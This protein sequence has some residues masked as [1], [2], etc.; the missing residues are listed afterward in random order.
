MGGTPFESYRVHHRL[1]RLR[2]ADVPQAGAGV[3]ERWLSNRENFGNNDYRKRG[4][5]YGGLTFVER[6]DVVGGQ[7]MVA[8]KKGHVYPVGPGHLQAVPRARRLDG[9][10]QYHRLEYYARMDE[11][12]KGPVLIWKSVQPAHALHL[13]EAL[14]ELT[15]KAA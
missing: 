11:K 9:D 1:G 6:S 15:F 12:P 10:G 5:L 14:V 8:A 4:F 2:H 3:F 13:P 7:T